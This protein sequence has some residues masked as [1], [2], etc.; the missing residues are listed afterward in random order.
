MPNWCFNTLT[1]SS[2]NSDDLKKFLFENSNGKDQILDFNNVIALPEEINNSNSNLSDNEKKNLIQKYGADN[3]RNWQV[4]NWGTKWN[5]TNVNLVMDDNLNYSFDS[6][7][8]PPVEWFY[9]LIQKYPE[10]DLNLDYEEPSCDLAGY[11]SFCNGDLTANKYELSV[12]VWEKCDKNIVNETI[13]NEVQKYELGDNKDDDIENITYN[14][15]D[16]LSDD[17]DNV[18]SIYC[19]VKEIVEN[20]I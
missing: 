19:Y 6:A 4:N 11:I 14:V 12:R 1:V 16:M 5:A 10:L 15:I 18:S 8:S 3:W 2:E 9:K 20:L 7:W 17:I 13:K